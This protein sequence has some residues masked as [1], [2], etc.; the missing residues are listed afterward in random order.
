MNILFKY[1]TIYFVMRRFGVLN[2]REEHSM[3]KNLI[4]T[5]L[6]SLRILVLLT[7][8]PLCTYPATFGEWS[9]AGSEFV[10]EQCRTLEEF[11]KS[12]NYFTPGLIV[13]ERKL[14]RVTLALSW[15]R[16]DE[17]EET[18]GALRCWS[19]KYWFS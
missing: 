18:Q 8:R 7:A 13:V 5:C 9:D 1:D 2:L 10:D 14:L 3:L 12:K 6:R 16:E 4:A 11:N 17:Q 15:P 19:F